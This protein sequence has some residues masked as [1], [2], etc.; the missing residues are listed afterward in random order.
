M[1]FNSQFDLNSCFELKENSIKF[2]H[3]ELSNRDSIFLSYYLIQNGDMKQSIDIIQ[4][5]A[6]DIQSGSIPYEDQILWLWLLGEYVNKENNQAEVQNY[7]KLIN[8]IIALAEDNWQKPLFSWIENLDK[9]IY[10]TNLASTYGALLAINNHLKDDTAQKLILKIKDFMFKKFLRGGKVVSK[11]GSDSIMGDICLIS[12]P[13]GLLDAGNQILV[14]TIKIVENELV[15]KG[16]RLSKDDT[17]YGGCTRNDLTCL[18]SWY[19]SE[20]GEIGRAKWLL[21]QVEDNWQRDGALNVLDLKSCKEQIYYEYWSQKDGLQGLEKPITYILYAIAGQNIATKE[22]AG[23]SGNSD[24]QIIH[25]AVGTGNPYIFSVSERFPRHPEENENV[26]LKAV[27]QPF[28][29]TQTVYALV[30][31]NGDSIKKA[32]M[33]VENSSDGEKYWE[34]DIGSFNYSDNVEYQFLVIDDQIEVKSYKFSF[35]VRKWHALSELESIQEDSNGLVLYFK[36]I[37]SN[38]LPCLRLNKLSGSTLKWSFY[39]EDKT[40]FFSQKTEEKDIY[41]LVCDTDKLRISRES[42]SFHIVNQSDGVILESYNKNGVGLIDLLMDGSSKVYKVRLNYAMDSGEKLFGLGERFSQIEY[43]GQDIDN[44]VYNQYRDQGLRTYI[45]VPFIISSGDYGIYLDTSMY[46]RFRFGTKLSD[47]MELEVN[48][49]EKSQSLD[50][51]SFT[52]SPKNIIEQYSDIVGR[53]V[54]PPKWSF[55][56]WMSSNNWDSQKEVYKQL[57]LMRKYKIPST[58]FVLEQWSDEATFYIFNDAQYEVK[59]GESYLEYKDFTFP[60]WGRWPDPKKMTDKLHEEGLKL[61]LW[62]APVMKYMDGIAHGQK[63]EDERAMLEHGYHIKHINGEPYRV[64]YFEWFK[65]SL[66]PDFTNPEAREWW[67]NKRLYLV[68]DIGIDGFKSDGGECIFGEDLTFYDGTSSDSMRNRYPNLYIE[69]YYNFI[70]QHKNGDGITFSR[71]GYTG[72]HKIPLHWAGDER[73]TF[74]A[75][76]ASV[77]AGLSCSMSGIPFWGWDLGGFNGEIPTAELYIRSAQ[78]AAFCPI[79]QYHAETKGE[80]NRDRTP[81]NIAERTGEKRVIEIYKK[82]ADLRMNLIPYIYQQAIKTCETGIPMMRAMF[83]EYPE[84]QSCTDLYQQY[85]FGEKLLVAPVMEEGSTV[86]DVYF[87]EGNWMNLFSGEVYE[88]SKYI[89]ARAEIDEIPVFVKEN[90]VIPMNL[91]DSYNLCSYVSNDMQNNSDLC[92][93][94]FVTVSLQSSYFD[95]LGN[96]ISILG[97]RT[98][99]SILLE[100][101]S[102][103]SPV[104]LIFKDVKGK[105]EVERD[106]IG[107]TA[108]DEIS[109]LEGNTFYVNDNNLVIKTNCNDEKVNIKIIMS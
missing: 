101:K 56:P 79:M 19:Y 11:L 39:F 57:E 80:F 86:K 67:L 84:D 103:F 46:A 30:S 27:T 85:F 82:Y 3:E 89:R 109:R 66:V 1:V 73:S 107:I 102:Q 32:E 88:G 36:C 13:F 60:E 22:T 40:T 75:F 29:E 15:S 108:V 9:D 65:R 96:K 106:C 48:I 54:L 49:D 69:S 92:F 6:D 90:S 21:K 20:R 97:K 74:K 76:V 24:V 17:Y 99:D 10:I 12:V 58:V 41:E 70:N 52:G 81:W 104:N 18:L 87:P 100:I 35:A 93:M 23:F 72:A 62:Q 16:A 77:K 7:N 91:S 5:I 98:D 68:K 28:K 83:M 105:V 63:D 71:A 51:Y 25:D 2:N 55:G 14:E 8:S 61:L 43:R 95:D 50:M 59:N 37:D 64:P 78:M 53:A 26:L 31:V 4:R 47:L 45:P 34:A 38:N 42:A 94:V 33:K 44:Y